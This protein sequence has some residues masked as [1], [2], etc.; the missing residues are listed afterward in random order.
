MSDK[1]GDDLN[2]VRDLATGFSSQAKYSNK[3]WLAVVAAATLSV[4]AL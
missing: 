4:M 3:V 2:I 1:I